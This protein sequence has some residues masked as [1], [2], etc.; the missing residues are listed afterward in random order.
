MALCQETRTLAANNVE[1]GV[2]HGRVPSMEAV[3]YSAATP[4]KVNVMSI[5]E[6]PTGGV[7][8]PVD[9]VRKV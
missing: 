8:A 3:V 7:P 9:T 6:A 4:P 1:A 2:W 5:F